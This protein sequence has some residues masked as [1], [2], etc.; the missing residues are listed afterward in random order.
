[1]FIKQLSPALFTLLPL[2]SSTAAHPSL[3]RQAPN[4]PPHSQSQNFNLI[5][6]VTD[7][8][9][10]LTPSINGWILSSYHVGAGEDYAVLEQDYSV[11]RVFF[12]NGTAE[13]VRFNQ[14]DLLSLEG[15]PPFP[16]GVSIDNPNITNTLGEHTVHI[17]AGLGEAGILL[18]NFPNPIPYLSAPGSASGGG[19]YA[20]NN[21]LPFG[22]A[23]Q[24]LYRYFEEITPEGCVDVTLLPQCVSNATV[25]EFSNTVN[26]YADVAGIDWTVYSA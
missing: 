23:V 20:C 4:Y 9:S 24:L 12:V 26:C 7:P 17:N 8:S 16:A 21:S 14:A 18:A 6:N 3:P 19:Y 5:A 25:E 1:M 13:E 15:T 2:L 22:P 10:D 11:G